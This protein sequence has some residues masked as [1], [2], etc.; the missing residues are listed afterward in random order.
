MLDREGSNHRHH[1][2]HHHCCILSRFSQS[3]PSSFPSLPPSPPPLVLVPILHTISIPWEI[4][5][6]PSSLLPSFDS[7]SS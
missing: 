2:L 1:H 6:V 3:V 7:M 4:F 5:P